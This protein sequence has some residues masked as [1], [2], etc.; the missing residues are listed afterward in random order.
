MFVI[1]W[2][3]GCLQKVHLSYTNLYSSSVIIVLQLLTCIS[4]YWDTFSNVLTQIAQQN[5][6]TSFKIY[7]LFS[8]SNSA[9][10]KHIAPA[11]ICYRHNH[12]ET[13]I[14]HRDHCWF[15]SGFNGYKL[16]ANCSNQLEQ[17]HNQNNNNIIQNSIF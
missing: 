9:T 16:T 17:C 14:E 2:G 12:T 4:E 8:H 11:K 15:F 3:G 7:E 10:S 5:N 1:F 6:T 13:T